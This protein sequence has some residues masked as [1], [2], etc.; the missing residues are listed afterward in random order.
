MGATRDEA[1]PA[2]RADLITSGASASEIAGG[3]GTVA[4]DALVAAA[5]AS[6][7][8]AT[9]SLAAG[10][11]AALDGAGAGA[12]VAAGTSAGTGGG[13][14]ASAGRCSTSITTLSRRTT[15]S[16]AKNSTSRLPAAMLLLGSPS[17]ASTC[18]REAPISDGCFGSA[19]GRVIKAKAIATPH[20]RRLMARMGGIFWKSVATGETPQQCRT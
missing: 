1:A 4:T 2:G 17:C 8:G 18:W 14:G 12:T 6:A 3:G 7:G 16:R 10:A 15:R 9:V 13:R 11:A 19:A 5:D 20:A